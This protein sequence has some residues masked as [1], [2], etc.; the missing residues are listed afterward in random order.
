MIRFSSILKTIILSCI[1]V[2]MGYL[3]I[4][5]I[6]KNMMVY[7]QMI[8][9]VIGIITAILSV[10]VVYSRYCPIKIRERVLME[11]RKLNIYIIPY[12]LIVLYEGLNTK[13]MYSYNN[14]TLMYALTPYLYV[15]FSYSLSYIFIVDGSYIPFL[16][17]ISILGI[18][19]TIIRIIGWFFYNYYR[20]PI[21]LGIVLQSPDWVRNGF[22]RIDVIP[23]YGIIV[24]LLLSNYL[25]SNK[26]KELLMLLTLVVYPVFI[27]Q[28]RYLTIVILI[29]TISMIY[30]KPS[31]S[32]KSIFT[33]ILLSI[34][35]SF[36]VIFGVIQQV[37]ALFSP[38]SL[39]GPSTSVRIEAMDHF[40]NLVNTTGNQFSGLGYL[41]SW[42]GNAA[43]L[44]TK[45]IWQNYYLSDL[46]IFGGL[47][48]FG[49][50]GIIV[51]GLLYY[52]GIKSVINNWN[53][54]NVNRVMVVG[55]F[56]YMVLSCLSLNIFDMNRAM[57]VP[58]YLAI[59][60]YTSSKS[61]LEH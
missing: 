23:L 4:F 35:L 42:N 43:Q 54:D 10:L 13:S 36:S 24:V 22:Q 14:I 61:R 11:F 56:I 50:L 48:V 47:V 45:N 18:V 29:T 30:L 60:C 12:L 53:H 31:E 20:L 2:N 1:A 26:L 17:K 38:D 3:L 27:T 16:E 15:I 6:D 57:D 33:K 40:Y 32:S 59:F 34:A 58:F 25:K 51:Y 49:L 46:G 21:F 8:I 44:L 37:V 19:M 39:Y 55:M 9:A 52:L 7:L 28:V 41:L 5:N